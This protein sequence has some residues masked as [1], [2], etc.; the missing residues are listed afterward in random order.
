MPQR[1]TVD[2]CHFESAAVEDVSLNLG[3]AQSKSMLPCLEM[4]FVVRKDPAR[5]V[6]PHDELST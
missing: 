6:L 4:Q 3:H 2:D 1:G 5:N